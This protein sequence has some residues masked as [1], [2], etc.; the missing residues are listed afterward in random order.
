[1]RVF[2]VAAP[3]VVS[4]VNYKTEAG[5]RVAEAVGTGVVWDAFGH[6]V[7]NYH[8]I[9]NV[10]KAML[11]LLTKVLVSDATGRNVT[12]C[13]VEL[14]GADALHDLAVLRIVGTD[15]AGV[16][17]SGSGDGGGGASG[18]PPPLTPIR[19]GRSADLKVGQYTFAIGSSFGLSR[20]LSAG[21]VSGLD[22]SIPSPVGTRI[23]GVVQTDAA[24]NAGNS[25]GPLLDSSARLVALNTATF[26]RSGTG[27]GSGVN[28]ALP[29]D[30]LA[31][32]VPKL[33]VYGNAM[34]KS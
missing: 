17:A 32:V 1:M 33:I 3:S 25:G 4:I 5:V 22:R 13:S 30:L 18:P 9:A 16:D 10:D 27:R 15:G 29:A 11:P 12:E 8:V 28:F 14:A 34:G 2:D 24:I 6:I 21:V 7:T 26:T 23:Y 20:T 31:D 19:L